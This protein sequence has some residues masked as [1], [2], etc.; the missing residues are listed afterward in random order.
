MASERPRGPESLAPAP[1]RL[2]PYAFLK[3]LGT[4]GMGEVWLA[5]DDRSGQLVALK[6]MLSH[7]AYDGRAAEMFR[8]EA[9]IASQLDHPTIVRV[10]DV[11]QI[12]NTH[13]LVMDFVEG[14]TLAHVLERAKRTKRPIPARIALA[15][16]AEVA[17]GLDH[18]HTRTDARGRPLGIVHRDVTP[19]NIMITDEGEVRVLDF[20]IAKAVDRV[21]RTQAG[22][23]KGKVEY[24]APEQIHGNPVDARTDLFSLGAVL[25]ELL[26][27][28]KLFL[29]ETMVGTLN[30]IADCKVPAPSRI[31]RE[32]S[33][34]ID[35]VVLR[36]LKKDPA[37][38][39]ESAAAMEDEIRA[40]LGERAPSPFEIARFVGELFPDEQ[41]ERLRLSLPP[42]SGE[43]PSDEIEID[44]ATDGGQGAPRI[45]MPL[46]DE[47]TQVGR[48]HA[49]RE[50]MRGRQAAEPTPPPSVRPYEPLAIA[51]TETTSGAIMALPPQAAVAE[52]ETNPGRAIPP[53]VEATLDTPGA[54]LFDPT[55]IADAAPG[56]S[57]FEEN[58]PTPP[59]TEAL[60]ERGR[61]APLDLEPPGRDDSALSESQIR[62]LGRLDRSRLLVVSGLSAL[63]IAIGI[64]V[65]AL[66]LR[67]EPSLATRPLP[68]SP[69]RI[70]PRPV[71]DP[72]AAG[73]PTVAPA[74]AVEVQD[75]QDS[76][77]PAASAP[78]AAT[79]A[80]PSPAPSTAP[81]PSAIEERP[82]PTR[83]PR[84]RLHPSQTATRTRHLR[85]KKR[86]DPEPDA[87]IEVE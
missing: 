36:A 4:G 32:V 5:R 30:A 49:E 67:S 76:P 33:P 34:A 37:G 51:A 56:P 14:E 55:E 21:A 39:F 23:F 2:G 27:G 7:L 63:A 43:P 41:A 13:F 47:P 83:E 40:L 9:K 15:V 44:E 87:E 75:P 82:H 70:V 80:E 81:S 24:L 18:A 29:K 85:P 69:A 16:V 50:E 11:G 62:D 31:N 60:P 68:T 1:T 6:R 19:P 22:A 77:S 71:P 35:A 46:E 12:D 58:T 84:A 3:R 28:K 42:D 52:E 59:A 8:D 20:G 72:P 48:S 61:L 79:V 45:R 26:T 64:L 57:P 38:R 78:P 66:F 10:V 54:G 25:F 53:S 17:A 86:P 74:R 65:G 73:T